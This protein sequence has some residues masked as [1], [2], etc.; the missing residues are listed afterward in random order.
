MYYIMQR[1]DIL[2][3]QKAAFF[4]LKLLNIK[5]VEKG[6]R[7]YWNTIWNDLIVCECKS[8]MHTYVIIIIYAMLKIVC[9]YIGTKI[10]Q[11]SF[12]KI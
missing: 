9:H 2:H 8:D 11:S 12:W 7:D 3:E 6:C 10:I 4:Y 5:I 1:F